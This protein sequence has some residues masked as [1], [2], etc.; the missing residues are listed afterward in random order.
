MRR[1]RSSTTLATGYETSPDGLVWTFK[2]RT[3]IKF[4]DGTALT[5]EDVAFT[6]NQAKAAAKVSMPGFDTAVATGTD[7]VE[8]RLTGEDG[9][10]QHYV[11]AREP[12]ADPDKWVSA[13][14]EG[15]LGS[16]AI[17]VHPE[18]VFTGHRGRTHLPRLHRGRHPPAR[19]TTAPPRH[20]TPAG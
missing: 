10:S 3:D 11:V 14:W 17:R 15:P 16:F 5:A 2:I 7:T 18:E 4:T 13:E 8:I 19:R 12:V 20:L 6:Y 1:T 9:S